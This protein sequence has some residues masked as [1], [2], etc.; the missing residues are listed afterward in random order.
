VLHESLIEHMA[1]PDLTVAEI[2]TWMRRLRYD[3]E[4]RQPDNYVPI[5]HLCEWAGV[6]RQSLYRILRSELG[7]T[8]N[9]RSRLTVAI[10]A[11]QAGLRWRR[12]FHGFE[13]ID[14][15]RWQRLPRYERPRRVA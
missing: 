7:L 4:F 13:I 2:E 3:P 9:H 15:E 12:V 8:R 6:P 11:V 1:A 10:R 5:L 14:P